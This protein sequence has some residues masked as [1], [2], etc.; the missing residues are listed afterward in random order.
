[1]LIDIMTYLRAKIKRKRRH[2]LTTC[3]AVKK[4][5]RITACKLH[6]KW[7]KHGVNIL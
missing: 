4:S 2:V 6:L 3:N 7:G 1:M 5:V